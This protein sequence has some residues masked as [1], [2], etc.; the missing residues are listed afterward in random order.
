MT[1]TTQPTALRLLAGEEGRALSLAEHRALHGALAAPGRRES[2]RL[3][4]ML[5]GAGLRGRGGAGFPAARK[6]AAAWES[7]S[8]GTVIANAAEGEPASRKDRTLLARNPHLVL[9]G[10]QLAARATRA[11]EV[12]VAVH[13]GGRLP[14]VVARAVQER[15]G[16][17]AVPTRVLEVPDRY[18]AGEASALARAAAGGPSIPGLHDQPLAVAGRPTVVLNAETLAGLALFLQRGPQWYGEVGTPAEPGTLLLTVR[19]SDTGAGV[20]ELPVGTPV[21]SALD[22]AGVGTAGL[23][24]V[25]VGGYFGAWLAA[26]D[27]LG[28]PL[29]HEGLRAAGGTLGAG[30]VAA[31]AAG[32]CGLR[33]TAEAV[34]YL[35]GESARQC[36]PC[37]NG[38]PAMATAL[39]ALAD[40]VPPVGTL[41]RLAALCGLVSG[42]G[43]C[44]HPDGTAALVRSALGVFAD[45]VRA[46]LEGGCGRPAGTALGVPR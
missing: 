22:V 46:H 6:L 10:A 31:L 32:E 14:Q 19:S 27:V 35:A 20:L 7:G 24:A 16:G 18:V 26:P 5:A 36:G 1:V 38:L 41:D 23:Q 45:D 12:V 33:A 29:S 9:D 43:L 42:R 44:H 40:G 2:R 25:L 17:D 37:L 21:G 39:E 13:R 15:A 11:K 28:V 4:A 30:V 3:Q 34:R 8:R